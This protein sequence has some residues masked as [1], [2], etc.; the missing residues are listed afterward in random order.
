LNSAGPYRIVST[1]TG[2][3][4]CSAWF[5]MML[6]NTT[7]N[8]V[9]VAVIDVNYVYPDNSQLLLT[10]RVIHRGDFSTPFQYQMFELDFERNSLVTTFEAE[11]LTYVGRLEY[12]VRWLGTSYVRVRR[13]LLKM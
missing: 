10:S 5:E 9:P 2:P 3:T 1:I 7:A 8:N 4:C 12:R 6:D 13:T 11:P